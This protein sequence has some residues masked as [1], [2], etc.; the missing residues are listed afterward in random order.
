VLFRSYLA[1]ELLKMKTGIKPV[2]VPY[3]GAAAALN[4]L[5]GGL[6]DLMF[7]AMPVMSEQV[8]AGAVT[9]IAVTGSKRSPALPSVPTFAEAG[10]PDFEV[11]GWFGL[12]A[13]A[14]TPAAVAQKLRDEVAKAVAAPDVIAQFDKQGMVPVASQPAQWGA[15]IKSELDRWGKVVKES[16]IKPE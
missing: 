1:T 4:D 16:G 15:Y 13:P 3:K 5:L 14:G 11:A 8:T 2:H 10:V 7:D 6:I 12:L 9:P